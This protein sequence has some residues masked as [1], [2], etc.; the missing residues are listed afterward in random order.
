MFHAEAFGAFSMMPLAGK[1]PDGAGGNPAVSVAATTRAHR[2]RV[3]IRRVE[4]HILPHRIVIG[5]VVVLEWRMADAKARAHY[6]PRG[7]AIGQRPPAA[8]SWSHSPADPDR[9]ARSHIRR[10][11]ACC[12]Q[13][14]IV[15]SRP[16]GLDSPADRTPTA[17]HRSV[18]ACAS[19][20][21]CP[22]RTQRSKVCRHEADPTF[23]SRPTWLGRSSRKLAKSLPKLVV[24]PFS[25]VCPSL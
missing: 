14:R 2:R 23:T 20:A 25:A 15:K 18:S 7:S 8:Q 5:V 17:V 22:A 11:A 9:W 19:A 24:S 4:R 21:T 12:P 6:C 13:G 1:P 3:T 16:C 10:H